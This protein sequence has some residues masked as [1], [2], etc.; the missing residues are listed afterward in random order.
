MIRIIIVDDEPLARSGIA[1]RLAKHPD[2]EVVAECAS[3][4][5]AAEQMLRHKP[6]LIFLDIWMRGLTG[7]ELLDSIPRERVP[8]VIFL[9][10][11]DQHAID[12][13]R[14]EALD[15][16]LKPVDD[17]RFDDALGRAR[18]LFTL[19]ERADTEPIAPDSSSDLDRQSEW[20][21]RF[22]VRTHRKVHFVRA[23]DIDWI[24]GLGDYAGLHAGQATH[25]IRESLRVLERRLD[26]ANFLRIH[27]SAIVNMNRVQGIT[28]LANQDSTVTLTSGHQIRGSR[29]YYAALKKL[30]CE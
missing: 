8:A 27:R 21:A 22:I 20:I 15:Y 16:L 25:L 24:E 10:A 13:F 23:A 18:R 28:R 26:P 1:A 5:D 30:M 6:D 4:E 2:C 9:T 17:E 3:A 19:R 12:A 7:I 14:H 29:T 11:H